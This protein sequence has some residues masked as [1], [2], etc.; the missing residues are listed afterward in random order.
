MLGKS[1]PSVADAFEALALTAAQYVLIVRESGPG[2]LEAAPLFE[3]L[4]VDLYELQEARGRA[5]EVHA[6]TGRPCLTIVDGAP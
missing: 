5:A 1:F 2:S 4:M 3:R 6:D